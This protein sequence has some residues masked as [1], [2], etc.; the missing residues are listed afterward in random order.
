MADRLAGVGGELAHLSRT[1]HS[2]APL[3]DAIRDHLTRGLSP[4]L[5][6]GASAITD[7]RDVIP[8]AI[9]AV[10]GVVEHFGMPV[11]PGNLM[12]LGRVGDVPVIGLPGCVRSPKING[13]DWVLQRLAA[14]VP[15]TR[16]DIMAMG[17]GGLLTEIASR[18][19]PREGKPPAPQVQRA[20]RIGAILLAAGQSR[21]MGAENKLLLEIAG[22]PLS[23]HALTALLD[24]GVEQPVLAVTGHQ[25]DQVEAV[26]AAGPSAVRFLRNPAYADG[27]STSLATGLAAI[28]DDW[29][30]A[31]IMLGDMPGVDARTLKR[32]IAAFN[33]LEGR[34]IVV[35][36]HQG[37]RG[38]P[39]LWDRRFFPEMR[40]LSGDSGAKH[41]IGAHAELVAEVEMDSDGVLVDLD[42]PE[43]LAVYRDRSPPSSSA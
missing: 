27:L 2:V 15:V 18:P 5:I 24:G 8:C 32:M 13:F 34:S 25:A 26:L 29:D 39:V 7:R 10:G 30:G 38:N 20:P 37:K 36:T 4:I 1:P 33:P 6:A 21:R 28:P 22:R 14:D 41:L 9:E 31:F 12:L 3:A 42:T 43:A 17:A 40:A 16:R 23:V 19:Q 11:D 35:P